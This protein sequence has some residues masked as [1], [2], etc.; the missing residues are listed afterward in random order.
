MFGRK[1]IGA[2]ARRGQ[3]IARQVGDYAAAGSDLA[4]LASVL[5]PELA[6]VLLPAAAGMRGLSM[7][8]RAVGARSARDAG[9]AGASVARAYARR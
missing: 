6:P 7:A 9:S 8:A 2:I 3:G 1:A 4:G 5:Q